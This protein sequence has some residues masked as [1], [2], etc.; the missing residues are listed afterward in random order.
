MADIIN[1]IEKFP[2]PADRK[3]LPA[4]PPPDILD[5]LPEMTQKM[6]RFCQA[7]VVMDSW[8][9]AYKLAYD[10]S[11]D[12]VNSRH[13]VTQLRRDPRIRAYCEKLRS[14]IEAEIDE[15]FLY[16]LED[17]IQDLVE[18]RDQAKAVEQ[19]GAAT[20]AQKLIGAAIGYGER[21]ISNDYLADREPPRLVIMRPDREKDAS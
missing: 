16:T 6:I 21:S 10:S 17:Y 5:G 19:F 12:Y 13:H 3:T 14:I 4:L 20:Q 9:Q 11:Q 18:I 1:A 7:A 2:D 15:R 8:F